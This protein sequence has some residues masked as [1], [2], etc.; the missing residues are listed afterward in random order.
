MKVGTQTSLAQIAGISLPRFN[1]YLNGRRN[2]SPIEAKFLG[3]ILNCDPFIW[4]KDG[5]ISARKGTFNAWSV[6]QGDSG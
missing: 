3:Q 6:R 2:A 5:D 1:H 4:M